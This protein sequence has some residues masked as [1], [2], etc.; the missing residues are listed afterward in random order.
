MS[1]LVRSVENKRSKN[2]FIDFVHDLYRHDPHYVPELRVTTNDKLNPKK[3]P[4]F[5]HADIQLF[6]AFRNEKIVGRIAA[7]HNREYIRQQQRKS[8]FIG[9]FD[10]VDDYDVSEALLL[11]AEKWL[12]SRGLTEVQG[13]TNLS[14]NDAAGLLVEGFDS[15]PV[16]EMTYNYAYYEK[17]F[18]RHGFTKEM[19]L[20]AY[21]IPTE[22][23][24]ERSIRL[25]QQIKERLK[26]K[27]YS[28]RG[29]KMKDFKQEIRKVK[30]IYAEAWE[31]NWGF[32]APTDA[33]FDFLADGMK[34]LIDDRYV[35]MAEKDGEL[36]GFA[37]GLLDINQV[38]K[39][40]KNGRLFP[41]NIF[42]LLLNKKKPDVVRIVLLGVLRDHRNI[43]IEAVF[44][45]HLI[46]AAR[47]NGLRGGEASWILES[48]K[49]MIRAAEKLNGH[50]YKTYRMFTKKIDGLY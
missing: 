29:V 13:P 20:F 18:V 3:N 24:N 45:S 31:Q 43:G 14:T 17:H 12:A 50:R 21:F 35:C 7:I 4:F 26:Q 39:N 37:F 23:A 40:F 8:G 34:P 32:V 15:S 41:F 33:E 27:G 46:Q 36:A 47:D 28:F 2:Q 42:K 44:F 6:L 11:K 5:A 22:T 48:N 10:F 38:T 16:V 19:N 9:Y 25:S 1:I 49:M 30:K